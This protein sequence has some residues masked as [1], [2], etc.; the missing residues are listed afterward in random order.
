MPALL[1]GLGVVAVRR[2]SRWLLTLVVVAYGIGVFLA[3]A[4]IGMFFLPSLLA[5]VLAQW[6]TGAEV[7]TP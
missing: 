1:T 5:I 2:S 6:R 4:S 3:M 7:S